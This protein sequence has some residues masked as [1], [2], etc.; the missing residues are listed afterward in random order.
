MSG[1]LTRSIDDAI[2]ALELAKQL[3]TERRV[4]G[5]S[6]M[7]YPHQFSHSDWGCKDSP[8]GC[9]MYTN[10]RDACIFCYEPDERK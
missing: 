5:S 3:I 2:E 10:D 6:P 8:T 9:C 4:L 7:D 1:N